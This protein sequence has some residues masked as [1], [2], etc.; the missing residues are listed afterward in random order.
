MEVL[1]A[2]SNIKKST[3]INVHWVIIPIPNNIVKKS[4]VLQILPLKS[5]L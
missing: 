2:A 5:I 4:L 1:T 3:S